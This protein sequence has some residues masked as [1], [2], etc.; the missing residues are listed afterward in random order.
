MPRFQSAFSDLL[1]ILDN[2]DYIPTPIANSTTLNVNIDDLNTTFLENV[3]SEDNRFILAGDNP[4]FPTVPDILVSDPEE[5]SGSSIVLSALVFYSGRRRGQE[6]SYNGYLYA[7]NKSQADGHRYWDCKD[8]KQYTSPCKGRLT[9][10]GSPEAP[11]SHPPS[12]KDVGVE[13]LLSNIRTDNTTETAANVV[14]G[15]I[16]DA[17]DAV[18]SALPQ[19]DHMKKQIN[20]YRKKVRGHCCWM[21]QSYDLSATGHPPPI[22][23]RG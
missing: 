13:H 9:T 7:H 22:Q 4:I 15:L 20:D 21:F 10:L 14:R 18:I 17:P 3:L 23:R 2:T 8:R 1:P 11:H 12:L 19:M 5:T 6:C 16:L